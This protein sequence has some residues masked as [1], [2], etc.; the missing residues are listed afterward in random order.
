MDRVTD[1]EGN[2]GF[3]AIWRGSSLGGGGGGEYVFK[4]TGI[5]YY[6]VKTQKLFMADSKHKQSDFK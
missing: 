5:M 6:W 1:T 2:T 3:T 4:S